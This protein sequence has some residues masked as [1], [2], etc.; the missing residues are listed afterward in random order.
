MG[1]AKQ[2]PHYVFVTKTL[3]AT[4]DAKSGSVRPF[5]MAQDC[6]P[7]RFTIAKHHKKSVVPVREPDIALQNATASRFWERERSASVHAAPGFMGNFCQENMTAKG[8]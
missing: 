5:T 6:G 4:S 3:N 1:S 2:A 7:G 8:G